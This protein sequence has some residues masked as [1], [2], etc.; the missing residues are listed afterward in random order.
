MR[1]LATVIFLFSMLSTQGQWRFEGDA[2]ATWSQA[3]ER[4]GELD[5]QHAGAHMEVLGHDDDGL[6]IHLF[7]LADG[8]F[9]HPDSLR[10]AGKSILWITN[11]IHPGEPDG[12]DA[13]LLLAQALLDSDQYMGLL[14]NTAVCIVPVYN[15]SGALQRSSTSR[16]NQM[17]RR[18]TASAPMP[19][20]STSTATSSRP[21]AATPAACSPPSA[22][23]TPTSTSRP[24]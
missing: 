3:V 16:A 22:P 14:A 7:V 2:S 19:A 9:P 11:G 24:T 18:S 5:R 13:S 8:T 10:A 4:F 12:V 21:T 23:G 15:V 1:H 20:T 17:A 6:P